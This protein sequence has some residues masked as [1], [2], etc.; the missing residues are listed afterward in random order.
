MAFT[1]RLVEHDVAIGAI[2]GPKL[3]FV[4]ARTPDNMCGE[5]NRPPMNGIES[6]PALI[7]LTALQVLGLV[8]AWVARMSEGSSRQ[9]ASQRVFLACLALVGTATIIALAI[10]P[11]CWL[12]SA[13][14]LSI[15]ILTAIC[16]FRPSRREAIR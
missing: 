1:V 3:L 6:P 12:T 10:G 7:F 5:R 11:G 14:T 9:T 8:S 15:M 13:T 16:D 4:V 2:G